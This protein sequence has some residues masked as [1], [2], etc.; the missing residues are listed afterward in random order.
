MEVVM[1]E[2]KCGSCGKCKTDNQQQAVDILIED[3]EDKETK[4]PIR[5]GLEGVPVVVVAFTETGERTVFTLPV[6]KEDQIPVLCYKAL[7]F[8][9]KNPYY[10][11]VP[12]GLISLVELGY[13][14]KLLKI[15]VVP[16]PR[17]N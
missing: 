8:L 12:E 5:K 15:K 13:E 6:Q 4:V 10:S 1:S 14:K 3:S 7:C 17:D 11:E 2:K 9:D 16:E